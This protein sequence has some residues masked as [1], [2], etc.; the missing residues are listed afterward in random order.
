MRP[1]L[2]SRALRM[3]MQVCVPHE[4]ARPRGRWGPASAHALQAKLHSHSGI[5]FPNLLEGALRA[6][7]GRGHP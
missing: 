3:R 2:T 7:G 1:G 6:G 4:A 5:P